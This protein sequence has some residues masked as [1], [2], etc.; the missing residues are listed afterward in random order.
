MNWKGRWSLVEKLAE[1]TL[2]LAFRSTQDGGQREKSS[3]SVDSLQSKRSF[4]ENAFHFS[5]LFGIV[6]SCAGEKGFVL[7]FVLTFVRNDSN[8]SC[9]L[10]E[11]HQRSW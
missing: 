5:S 9:V 4:S 10:R 3:G 7:T 2:N 11:E 8:E 1:T 6:A